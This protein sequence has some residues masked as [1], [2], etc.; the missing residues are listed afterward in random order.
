MKLEKIIDGVFLHGK[1]T[2]EKSHSLPDGQYTV[3]EAIDLINQEIQTAVQ[4]ERSNIEHIAFCNGGDALDRTGLYPN[5]A[6]YHCMGCDE[7]YILVTKD[8]KDD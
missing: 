7:T 3:Q 1:L 4:K 5:E 2:P 6:T 8:T